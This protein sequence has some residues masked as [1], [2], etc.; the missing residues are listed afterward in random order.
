MNTRLTSAVTTSFADSKN[1]R[2]IVAKAPKVAP[3]ANVATVVTVVV[4]VEIMTITI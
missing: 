2:S 3:T 4:T 1:M